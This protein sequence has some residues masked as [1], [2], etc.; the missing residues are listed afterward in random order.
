MTCC[1]PAGELIER[2]ATG[3]MA[4]ITTHE[5][6]R[7]GSAP[8]PSL[9]GFSLQ[10]AG[11][12]LMHKASLSEFTRSRELLQ[13]LIERHPLAPAPRAWLAKCGRAHDGGPRD[14]THLARRRGRGEPGRHRV[15]AAARRPGAGLLQRGP[16]E[17]P[18][19]RAALHRRLRR[20]RYG[21]HRRQHQRRVEPRL[22][23]WA[24]DH[25]AGDGRIGERTEGVG[26]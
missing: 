25:R 20:R 17:M 18:A 24:V 23:R 11:T 8:L 19:R 21:A 6:R 13:H 10:L 1:C 15:R 22:A 3:V 2:I 16:D 5:L 12:A 9:Q 4:A 14:A 26:P 7:A